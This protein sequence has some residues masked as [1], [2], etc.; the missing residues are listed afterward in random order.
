M[1]GV[2]DSDRSKWLF[3][4]SPCWAAA[5]IEGGTGFSVSCMKL[6]IHQSLP[7]NRGH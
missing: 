1:K 3:L 7:D 6:H 5:A 2:S 4:D